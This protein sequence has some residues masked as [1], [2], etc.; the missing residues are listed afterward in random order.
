MNNKIAYAKVSGNGEFPLDML[1]YDS[2]CPATEQDATNIR[3]TISGRLLLGGVW[4]IFVKKIL[5]ERRRKNDKVFTDG[6]WSS[7]GC[8]IQEVDSPYGSRE[9]PESFV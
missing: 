5:L 9:M 7:F 2:C 4:V 3:L 6:R 1:R 8:S